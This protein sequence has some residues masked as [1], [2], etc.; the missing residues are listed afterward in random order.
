MTPVVSVVMPLEA[1]VGNLGSVTDHV[2]P[3]EDD[4]MSA[5]LAERVERLCRE[6]GRNGDLAD[7]FEE[8]GA[9][10]LLDTFIALITQESA[11]PAGL[12]ATLDAIDKALASIGLHGLTRPNRS[13]S[14]LPGVRNPAPEVFCYVCPLKRCDRVESEDARC[15]LAERPLERVRLA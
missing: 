11:D 2:S 9:G 14:P 5:E 7:M 3:L 12:S 4:P 8:A 13:W 6:N 10:E 1:S 15:S